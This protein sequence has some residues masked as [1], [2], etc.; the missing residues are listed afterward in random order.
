MSVYA[1]KTRGAREQGAAAEASHQP[2]ISLC[3]INATSPKLS[4]P[5]P[6]T[7]AKIPK[8]SQEQTPEECFCYTRFSCGATLLG[9]VANLLLKSQIPSKKHRRTVEKP[10]H[11]SV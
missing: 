7:M 4:H 11:H 10:T 3:L 5:R 9:N 1:V 8:I 6:S 2:Q